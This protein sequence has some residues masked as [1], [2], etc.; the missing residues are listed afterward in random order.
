MPVID[1]LI[2]DWE[3]DEAS[4]QAL[5]S[6]G[7]NPLTDNNTVGASGGWRDFESDNVESFSHARQRRFEHGRH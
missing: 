4:G 6:H 7:S 1:S 3:M 5:D 2:G